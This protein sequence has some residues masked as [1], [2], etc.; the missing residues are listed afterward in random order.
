MIWY[1]TPQPPSFHSTG[2][3]WANTKCLHIAVTTRSNHSQQSKSFMVFCL[4]YYQPHLSLEIWS[5][6]PQSPKNTI[7]WA[8]RDI[9]YT[10]ALFG[11]HKL[12]VEIGCNNMTKC[13]NKE[14]FP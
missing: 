11:N 10:V 6:V 5:S 13:S 4:L 8:P 12:L 3:H 2:A 7:K 1:I 14:L 9:L